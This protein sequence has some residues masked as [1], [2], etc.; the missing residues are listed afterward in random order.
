MY[1]LW[2]MRRQSCAKNTGQQRHRQHLCFT[3]YVLD[4]D[5]LAMELEVI[6]LARGLVEIQSPPSSTGFFAIAGVYLAWAFSRKSWFHTLLAG[7]V[8]LLPVLQERCLKSES[9][10][11]LVALA[12]FELDFLLVLFLSPIGQIINQ[13]LSPQTSQSNASIPVEQILPVDTSESSI[14][15]E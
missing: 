15:V 7:S 1:H 4:K 5:I 3:G 9:S 11:F 2:L 6:P 12:A 14:L 10:S 13:F 8:F